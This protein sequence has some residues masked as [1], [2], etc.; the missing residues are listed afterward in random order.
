M[1]TLASS[2]GWIRVT[3][4]ASSPPRC[5]GLAGKR[6]SVR[7]AGP[8]RTARR[9]DGWLLRQERR[10]RPPEDDCKAD[11]HPRRRCDG[12]RRGVLEMHS[13]DRGPAGAEVG[14][15]KRT[16]EEHKEAQQLPQAGVTV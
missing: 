4:T 3:A 13:D 8:A 6:L 7:C 16:R 12:Q 14:H 15:E 9:V 1:W 2:F 10:G 11:A 5:A